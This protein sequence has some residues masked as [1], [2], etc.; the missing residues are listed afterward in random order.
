MYGTVIVPLD[1]SPFAETALGPAEELAAAEDVPLVLLSVSDTDATRAYLHEVAD[2]SAVPTTVETIRSFD[3][4]PGE[5]IA[6]MVGARPDALLVMATHGRSG[7]RRAVLGSVTEQVIAAVEQPILLTG[8]ACKASRPLVG[9]RMVVGLDGSD[10]A[11]AVLPH[12]AAWAKAFDM[13]LWLATVQPPAGSVEA[14]VESNYLARMAHDLDHLVPTVNWDTL[15]GTDPAV[16]LV[17]L[18]ERLDARCIA[19]TTHGRSGLS[20]VA[21]GSVA[22]AITHRSPVPVLVH[23][24]A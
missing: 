23:R 4:L 11:E 20:R 18:A 5:A 8:P 2:A 14:L 21:L 3:V 24:A 9:G 10:R 6:A 17:G 16:E 12:A 7:V 22:M 19:V 1:G 13:Q 15:H